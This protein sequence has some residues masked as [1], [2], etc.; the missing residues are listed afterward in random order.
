M[1]TIPKVTSV[2]AIDHRRLAVLFDNRIIKTY[3]ITPLLERAMFKPLATPAFFKCVQ[4]DSGGYGVYWN[5]AIDISEYELW[6]H[7]TAA[8]HGEHRSILDAMSGDLT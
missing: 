8:P 7:G 5:A 6:S 4:V 3:D 1:T 2:I